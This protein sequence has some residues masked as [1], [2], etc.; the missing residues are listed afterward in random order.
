[1]V[2]KMGILVTGKEFMKRR[3]WVIGLVMSVV[4]VGGN[5]EAEAAEWELASSAV[6]RIATMG[7]GAST[8]TSLLPPMEPEWL[9]EVIRESSWPMLE[10]RAWPLDEEGRPVVTTRRE[11]ERWHQIQPGESLRRLRN[12]YRKT[13]AQLQELNPE[14]DLS[15]LKVG[16]ELRVWRRSEEGIAQSRGRPQSGRLIYGEPLPLSENYI[17]LFPYRAFGTHYTVS[18]VVRILD[19]Y[20]ETF[21][22]ADPLMVGD[23]SFRTGRH[24]N[25]HNSHQAGRDVD[26]TLPRLS[27][28]PNY[29][30]FHHVRRDQLDAER[31]LWLLTKLLEGGYVQHIFLDWHHQR[32]LYRLAREQGAPEEWLR[33]VFE[34]PYRGGRGIIRH[35][36]GHRGHFHIRFACQETDRW[37]G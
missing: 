35:A 37:C 26:I 33:E 3:F 19:G 6:L 31:T 15:A 7:I 16:D 30:R 27:P 25:P 5:Q 2:L 36:R 1:M 12:I 11:E 8:T 23:I 17:V 14:V 4:L 13:T 29:Q 24:I 32:T 28:P 18:E 20:Y 9:E 22:Q 10:R 21:P 34:F